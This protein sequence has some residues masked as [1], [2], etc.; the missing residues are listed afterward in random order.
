[1]RIFSAIF[2]NPKI[3]RVIY[4][5]FTVIV[6]AF[7][8]MFAL[9]IIGNIIVKSV[10]Y[11]IHFSDEIISEANKNGLES[12]LVFA[13]VKVESSFS[14]G[15]V[16]NKGAVGLMQITPK[17]G[18][19]IAQMLGER[20]YDLSDAKTNI[21]FGCFYIRYLLDRFADIETAM[22]AYNAGESKVR[23]WLKNPEYSQNGKTLCIIPYKESREYVEKITK[24]FGI[25]KKLYGNILD[26]R[27]NFE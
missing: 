8:A 9:L 26:K 2:K 27:K 13:V 3:S 23:E 16:S 18:E 22:V 11:P 20:E 15:A 24:T 25:Y 19:Y 17:T 5:I 4:K 6:F 7:W 14:A 12:E 21:R 1:M 10:F